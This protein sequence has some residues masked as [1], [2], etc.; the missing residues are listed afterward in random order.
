MKDV[1]WVIKV[2]LWLFGGFSLFALGMNLG[3]SLKKSTGKNHENPSDLQMLANL[4][5][6]NYSFA[7]VIKQN[8]GVLVLPYEPANEAHLAIHSAVTHASESVRKELSQVNSPIRTKRRINEASRFFEDAL[9]TQ[10]DSL[11]NFSCQI[12]KTSEGK[13][14]RS[15]YPDLR[16]EHLPSGTVAYLDPKLFEETSIK[17]SFRTFY[18]EPSKQIKVTED[19]LHLLVGFPH[20]GRAREWTFATAEL[21]DLADLQVNLKAEFSASN[22][23][24]YHQEDEKGLTSKGQL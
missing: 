5:G 21:V 19:A 2:G 9:L 15:G 1:R 14:Q 6:S 12:P 8:S 20:D 3:V 16:V 10:L 11:P 23:D 4:T 17:S 22:R 7:E 13:E 18:F 24:L